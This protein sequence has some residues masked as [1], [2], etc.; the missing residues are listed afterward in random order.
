MSNTQVGGI[1]T[2]GSREAAETPKVETRTDPAI[3]AS[4]LAS[5][6]HVFQAR[7][8]GLVLSP[9]RRIITYKDGERQE[10]VPYTTDGS[11]LDMVRFTDGFLST[12]DDE[13]DAALRES[14]YYG[15]DFW[16]YRERQKEFKQAQAEEIR[17]QL[18]A[19]P[20]LAAAVG[21]LKPSDKKDWD[22]KTKKSEPSEEELEALTRPGK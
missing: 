21:P 10:D 1:R 15:L 13:L 19:D 5:F 2:V 14:K 9:K 17:R 8:T 7:T 4:R 3:S 6:K 20:E 22:V 12:N 11:R 16:D 18:A